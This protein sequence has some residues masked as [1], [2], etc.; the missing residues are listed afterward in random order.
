VAAALALGACGTTTLDTDELEAELVE[1][2]GESAGV[3]PREVRCPEDIE[4]EEG[5][6]FQC[7]LVA[8]NGDEARVDVRLTDDRGGFDAVVPEQQ[9]R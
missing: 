4:A 9:F 8:P 2:L 7:T 1:Q 6:R 5:K 3:Q